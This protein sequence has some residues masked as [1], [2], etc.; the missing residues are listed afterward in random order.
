MGENFEEKLKKIEK[1]V[2][3]LES[4]DCGLD[5]SI[6]LYS[7]GTKLSAECKQQ[8]EKARQKIEQLSDYTGE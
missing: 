4:G 3:K 8:L 5:E 2:A 6:E 7:E 1:I